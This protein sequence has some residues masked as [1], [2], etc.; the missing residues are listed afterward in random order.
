MATV[1]VQGFF[2]V[3]PEER[4]RFIAASEASMR[5]SRGEDGCQEYVLAADPLDGDRVVLSE[6]WESMDHLRAH[7]KRVIEQRSQGGSDRPAPLGQEI[8]VYEVASSSPLG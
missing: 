2:S 7:F 8:V 6:R 5:E 4:D 1:I 3:K